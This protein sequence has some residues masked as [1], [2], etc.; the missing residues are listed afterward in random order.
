MVVSTLLAEKRI[1][2]KNPKRYFTRFYKNA[3]IIL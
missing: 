1:T 3:R 2:E